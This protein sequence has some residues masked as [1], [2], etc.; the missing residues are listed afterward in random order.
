MWTCLETSLPCT[1]NLHLARLSVLPEDC[2]EVQEL[3]LGSYAGALK[4]RNGLETVEIGPKRGEKRW[5]TVE[6]GLF[7]ASEAMVQHAQDMI[8]MVL[9]LLI[10]GLCRFCYQLDDEGIERL[11]ALI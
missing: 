3:V 6:N 7:L 2:R 5:K 8:S 4:A 1:R 9:H 10:A 11:Q